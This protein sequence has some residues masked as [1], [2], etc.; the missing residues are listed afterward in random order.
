MED[1]TENSSKRSTNQEPIL[2]TKG[3]VNKISLRGLLLT[4]NDE[5]HDFQ[6]KR[7]LACISLREIKQSQRCKTYLQN[8]N[9]FDKHNEDTFLSLCAQGYSKIPTETFQEPSEGVWKE[10]QYMSKVRH[11]WYPERWFEMQS[12]SLLELSQEAMD[13]LQNILKKLDNSVKEANQEDIKRSISNFFCQFGSHVSLG[14]FVT[15]GRLVEKVS[16]TDCKDCDMSALW[17]HLEE[18]FRAMDPQK[19]DLSSAGGEDSYLLTKRDGKDEEVVQMRHEMQIFGGNAK[20]SDFNKWQQS[21]STSCLVISGVLSLEKLKPLWDI[22]KETQD[23]FGEFCDQLSGLLKETWHEKHEELHFVHLNTPRSGQFQKYGMTAKHSTISDQTKTADILEKLHLKK[24]KCSLTSATVLRKCDVEDTDSSKDIM[25]KFIKSIFSLDYRGRKCFRKE[26]QTS[27]KDSSLPENTETDIFTKITKKKKGK[28]SQNLNINPMDVTFAILHCCNPFLRQEVLWKMVECRLAVPIIL[29][30]I[31]NKECLEFQLWGLRKVYKSWKSR[32]TNV[33]PLER[34]VVL[35]PLPIVCFLRFGKTRPSFSKSKLLNKILGKLQGNSDHSFFVDVED[36]SSCATVSK[37]TVEVAWFLPEGTCDSNNPSALL[38]AVTFFNLRG[39]AIDFP[40]Q[41]QF[42]CRAAD[43]IVALVEE[44]EYPKY[45]DEIRSISRSKDNHLICIISSSQTQTED[46]IERQ[47]SVTIIHS[48]RFL[49]DIGADICQELN[50]ILWCTKHEGMKKS[51]FKSLESLT[52]LCEQFKIQIDEY[53]NED[54]MKGKLSAENVKNRVLHEFDKYKEVN[55]PLQQKLWK[56]WADLDKKWNKGSGHEKFASIEHYQDYL[57]LEMLQIRKEQHNTPPT[58]DVVDIVKALQR[59]QKERQYFIAWLNLYLNDLSQDRLGPLRRGLREIQDRAREINAEKSKLKG[60]SEMSDEETTRLEKLKDEDET[61]IKQTRKITNK[62]DSESLGLE[63]YMRELGQR[64]EA[65]ETL[66]GITDTDV[67]SRIN[68]GKLPDIAAELLID[69]HPFEILDG[70]VGRVPLKWVQAVFKSL[71][72]KLGDNKMVFAVSVLGIQ[73]SGKSTLLNSMFGVRFAVSA[74]RCTRGVFIQLLKVEEDLAKEIRCDY[75]IVID[76]E[77]LKAPERSFRNDFR[78]DN[79]LATFALC[80]ADLTLINIA[81]QTVGKDMTDVLQ[82]AAHAFIRMKE[83]RIKSS[84]RIIQQFVADLAAVDKNEACTQAI[85]TSLDEAISVAA[86]EE[87][88]GAL[89]T[90]FSDVFNLERDEDIQ[91]IPSLWQGSMAPPNHRYSER[92]IQLKKVILREFGQSRK[93]L[94]QFSERTTSVWNAVKEE[95]FIF[96]FQSC[97]SALRYKTFQHAYGKWVGDM[98]QVVMEWE[99][100]AKQRLKHAPKD[101][102]EITKEKLKNEIAL[103]ISN[104]GDNVKELIGN[105]LQE[106]FSDDEDQFH[107]FEVEFANDLDFT[108][109]KFNQEVQ[110]TLDRTVDSIKQL[111]QMDVLLPKCKNQ[112][113][114]KARKQA[115]ELRKKYADATTI[116]TET[117]KKEIDDHFAKVWEDWIKEICQDYPPVTVT[118]EDVQTEFSSYL[119]RQGERNDI[120]KGLKQELGRPISRGEK[121]RKTTNYAS[122]N[123]IGT[124]KEIVSMILD[125]ALATLQ[126]DLDDDRAYDRSLIQKLVDSTIHGLNNKYDN[127]T[128]TQEVKINAVLQVCSRA[129]PI[130]LEGRTA[131]NKKYSLREHL[132]KEKENLKKDFRAL[133]S[134]AFQDQRASESLTSLLNEKIIDLIQ[135]YLGPAIYKAV[136]ESCPYFASKFAMFGYVLEDMA[137]KEEFDS[138]Y[139][140]IFDLN[141]F[142]EEWSRSKIAEICVKENYSGKSFV[143]KIVTDKIEDVRV[144]ILHSINSTLCESESQPVNSDQVKEENNSLVEWIKQLSQE[145]SSGRYKLSLSDED[146]RNLLLFDVKDIKYFGGLVKNYAEQRMTAD[147]FKELCLPRVGCVKEAEKMLQLLP[148]KPHEEIKKHVSG[149]TEQCPICHAPCDNMTKQHEKHRAELHYPEGLVGCAQYSSGSLVYTICTSSITTDLEYREG[150]VTRIYSEFHKDFPNWVIQPIQN[151]SPL[152]YWKWVMNRFNE[153]FA[154]LYGRREAKLPEGWILITKKQAI[155]DLR[156]AY[157][158]R[159]INSS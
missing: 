155:E 106:N 98:R 159:Q 22:V 130:I 101:Q 70:D 65:H 103:V 50:Q 129:I 54:N 71:R 151:D 61:L 154:R 53:N 18:E 153:D 74:G 84:C 134:S 52:D 138:Y 118:E 66:K 87:G 62:L 28:E 117:T 115:V 124:Q 41:K 146:T 32:V 135:N 38:D 3:P 100:N 158:T 82:I 123:L 108:Q 152:K 77:G 56:K 92:I 39:D 26:S 15:G 59:P 72:K 36:E 13:S 140:F 17:Y 51:P 111:N 80:L 156:Q 120:S 96:K 14:P 104:E 113:R 86:K 121:Y 91:Y 136:R 5:K 109:K 48:K 60:N 122:E 4:A 34:S 119:I 99:S 10:T 69:G 78:H 31:D 95:N 89:Y 40:L 83:V 42:L 45:L 76:T 21:L 131:Y 116:D 8:C 64:F 126:M 107:T 12:G 94:E 85:L 105:Y 63:H 102:L 114:E 145:L 127:T 67:D 157:V 57:K 43:V 35:H 16:Y 128:L 19:V 23:M 110:E 144:E 132:M 33:S 147:I 37:G 7:I 55:L 93:T 24:T 27:V 44:E 133:C 141:E 2:I 88:Y 1:E 25:W 112:L 29:P 139:R 148:T 75:V 142:L 20:L 68:V 46:N 79:E 143:E 58:D 97:V 6:P 149:C 81:G 49:T 73:S 125:T 11:T 137:E 30:G 90:R 150:N 9:F 47:G